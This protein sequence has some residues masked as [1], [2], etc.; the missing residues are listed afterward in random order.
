MSLDVLLR[1]GRREA[2]RLAR[3]DGVGRDVGPPRRRLRPLLG[4][5]R[6]A[7]APLREDAL[8]PGAARPRVPARLAGDRLAGAPP[9]ARRARRLRAARPRARPAAGSSP[10]RT[11]T[12]RA[13]RAASTRGRPTSCARCSATT[14]PARRRLLG[15]H[16]RRQLRGPVDPEPAARPRQLERPPEIEALRAAAVRR[17]VE[18]R[19]GPASTTRCSP[20]GTR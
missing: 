10:P 1:A 7:R 11:P 17:A 9:G 12:A 5:R 14:A 6:V 15:R 2:A 18:A 20:S 3:G 16:R 8:R 13:R 4:R 19:C